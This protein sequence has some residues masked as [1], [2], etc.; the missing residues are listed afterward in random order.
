MSVSTGFAAS[1]RGRAAAA[2]E[3]GEFLAAVRALMAGAP[4]VH[5]DETFARAGGATTFV[6]VA[7]TDHL[8]LL[9]VEEVSAHAQGIR[10]FATCM[11]S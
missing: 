3:A 9:H 2:I 8:R 5:A 1:L 11:P 4:V 10:A 6:H 7:C